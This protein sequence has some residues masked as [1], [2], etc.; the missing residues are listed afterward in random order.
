MKQSI[1]ILVRT[2]VVLLLMAPAPALAAPSPA[3]AALDT[4]VAQP[5]VE[6][7]EESEEA[8]EQPWTQRFLAPAMVVLGVIAVGASAAYYVVQ[9]RG[10]YRLAE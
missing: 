2:F 8:D 7:V 9:I 3:T 4:I 10:R 5:A 6:V 1:A